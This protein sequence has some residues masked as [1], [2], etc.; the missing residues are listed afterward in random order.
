MKKMIA[1]A[2]LLAV[3]AAANAQELKFG[4]VNYFLKQSQ[5]NVTF[6]IAQTYYRSSNK[7]D[8]TVETR[9]VLFST[10]YSYA[11]ADNLNAF[12]GLEYAY[13]RNSEDK[14]DANNPKLNSYDSDGLNN[15]ALGLN[16]RLLNQG[17]S[18]YNVDFGA[19]AR[20]KLQD[21]ERGTL[22]GKDGNFTDPRSSLELN[23][24]MGRKWNEANEWQLAVGAQYF[25]DGEFDQ[26]LA[27]G[28]K[29]KIDQDSSTD[30]FV[31]GTYQYRPVNEFMMLLSA[32]ATRVAEIDG[33]IN[34]DEHLD[35]DFNFTAK[36]L[37][38][39]TFIAKFNYGQSHNSDYDVKAAGVKDEQRKRHENTFGLGVDFL[40]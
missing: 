18:R 32:Q 26:K 40:F 37:I 23:A 3:A 1:V 12:I 34:S 24:R 35:M 2:G 36:Y 20:I 14:T 7:A 17:T 31:R 19:I 22:G 30:F 29:T 16:Y 4:D 11:F 28:G 21:A 15:P 39:S 10:T 5:Q 27:A 8:T 38:T 13:D 6:D 9:G 25:M 33:D